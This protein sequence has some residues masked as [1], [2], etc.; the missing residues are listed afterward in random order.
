MKNVALALTALMMI[1]PG[2]LLAQRPG[3]ED[4]GHNPQGVRPTRVDFLARRFGLTDAQKQQAAKIL[5]T[6]GEARKDLLKGL[7][8]AREDLNKAVKAGATDQQIE[9]LAGAMG[10]L[11]GQLA[12]NEAKERTKLRALLTAEQ[13]QRFDQFPEPGAGMM[14][15]GFRR[16]PPQGPWPGMMMRGFRGGP[17]QGPGMGMMMPGFCGPPPRGPGMGL[18]MPGFAGGPP[19]GPP[20]PSEDAPE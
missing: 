14:M 17:P 7:K 10:T 1:L 18:M 20:P 2:S 6:T 5:N 19:P 11:Q 4:F 3:D 15:R 13:Q 8:Q 9:K 16:G 12:A